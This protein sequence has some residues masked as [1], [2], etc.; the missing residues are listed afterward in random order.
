[1]SI[2]TIF[3][4]VQSPPK[5]K[6][7]SV[8]TPSTTPATSV[9]D[10]V[11][12]IDTSNNSIRHSDEKN[13]SGS[14]TAAIIESG[15]LWK[16]PSKRRFLGVTTTQ[17]RF[18]VLTTNELAYKEK[19]DDSEYRTIWKI[20]SEVVSVEAPEAGS[21]DFG[22]VVVENGSQRLMKLTASDAVAATKFSIAV[23]SCIQ[24]FVTPFT[25]PEKPAVNSMDDLAIENDEPVPSSIVNVNELSPVLEESPMKEAERET[26]PSVGVEL[27][28]EEV[29][30]I[31]VDISKD[32]TKPNVWFWGMC[33]SAE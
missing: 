23:T 22:V 7:T 21:K 11:D 12:A 8:G 29:V 4:K 16:Q 33:C 5:D 14:L 15:Y 19:E 25:A 2:R 9:G 24:A 3:N 1:M 13:T 6:A 32:N 27:T 10:S 30:S 20:P 17:K 31:P 28:E 26:E 18:F